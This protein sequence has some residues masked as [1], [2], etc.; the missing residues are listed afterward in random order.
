MRRSQ[1]QIQDRASIDAILGR[2]TIGRLATVGEDG[3][4]YILPVNYVYWN[5]AIYFHSAP[6]GEKIDNI[7]RNN[8]VCFEVDIPLSYIDLAYNPARPV[9]QLHQFYHCVIIRGRAEIIENADEKIQALN[10]LVAAHEPKKEFKE[11]TEK[12]KAVALCCVIAVR[13]DQISGKSDLAQNKS[14]LEKSH[15]HKYLQERNM[16]GDAEAARLLLANTD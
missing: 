1:C 2:C 3:Y 6:E 8:R 9:C 4:P 11:V 12:T 13:I 16:P 14:D 15:L 7:L 10:A 5:G